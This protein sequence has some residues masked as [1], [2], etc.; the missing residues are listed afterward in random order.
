MRVELVCRVCSVNFSLEKLVQGVLFT[1]TN[2]HGHVFN[3]HSASHVVLD[4]QLLGLDSYVLRW[5]Q[6]IDHLKRECQEILKITYPFVIDLNVTDPDGDSLV[7]LAADLMVDLLNSP[8][9]NSSV[10]VIV[11]LTQHG[12]G[13]SSTS[14]AVA[15]NSSIVP[16]NGTVDD[17]G[18]GLVVDIILGGVM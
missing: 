2:M 6:Q 16:C 13:L 18:S 14:L 4:G 9:N 3:C 15:H 17:L 1:L 8:R 7:K 10:L 12:E 5:N 11:G